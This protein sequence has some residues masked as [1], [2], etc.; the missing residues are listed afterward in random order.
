METGGRGMF[1]KGSRR[2]GKL[3]MKHFKERRGE[4]S[5]VPGTQ[6]AAQPH[7]LLTE[8]SQKGGGGKGGSKSS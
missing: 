1:G 2:E 6:N 5:F 7:L 8:N 3:K 4:G